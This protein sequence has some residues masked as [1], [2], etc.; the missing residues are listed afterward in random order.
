LERGIVLIRLRCAAARQPGR[1]LS[2][3]IVNPPAMLHDQAPLGLRHLR[4]FGQAALF[5]RRKYDGRRPG[6]FRFH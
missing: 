3:D 1:D 5:S 4:L 6:L 2:E